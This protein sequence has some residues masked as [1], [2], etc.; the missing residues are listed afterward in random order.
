MYGSKKTDT[1]NNADIYGIYKYL[2]LSEEENKGKL[3]L[4]MESANDL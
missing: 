3:L 2:Y 4:R 1:I